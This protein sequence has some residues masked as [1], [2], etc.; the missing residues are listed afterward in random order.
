MRSLFNDSEE[1]LLYNSGLLSEEGDDVMG[2]F[3]SVDFEES[4][5]I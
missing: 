4:M 3:V 2:T 5:G 1:C